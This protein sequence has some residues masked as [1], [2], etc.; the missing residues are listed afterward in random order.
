MDPKFP[1]LEQD[2]AAS[3]PMQEIECAL[4]LQEMIRSVENDPGQMRAAIYEFA[5]A[6]LKIDSAWADKAE[7][8]RLRTAL[9]TAIRGVEDFS[10]RRV[11]IELLPPPERRTHVAPVTSGP[12]AHPVM[13]PVTPLR[14]MAISG[15]AIIEPAPIYPSPSVSRIVRVRSVLLAAMAAGVVV[16]FGVTIELAYQ[17]QGLSSFRGYWSASQLSSPSPPS[18]PVQPHASQQA[19]ISADPKHAVAAASSP[20]PFP[21]PSDY[22]VYAL[23]DGKLVELHPLPTRVP[24]KRIAISTPIDRPSRTVLSNGKTRFIIFR[25]DLAGDAPD[26]IDVRVVAQVVRAI[27]FDAV[28]KPKFDRVSNAWNIRNITHEL[29]VRPIPGNP[30]MLLV[31]SDKPEFALASGRY[32]LVLKDQGYDFTIAGAVTDMAQCL[33]RTDAA[34]GIFYSQCLKF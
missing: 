18:P 11:E 9:E 29:R 4:I 14:A 10:I 8:E 19:A 17:R 7:R 2:P 5:R 22:G 21:L 6:R 1:N 31:Q 32:V 3:H 26:R 23:S 34:N 24:D 20:P 16:F 28:G 33:E 27:S 15:D 30:E 12:S 25:R 13:T